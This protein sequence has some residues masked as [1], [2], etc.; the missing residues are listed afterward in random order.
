MCDSPK[1][2]TGIPRVVNINKLNSK[3]LEMT[4]IMKIFRKVDD[5]FGTQCNKI[6]LNL[7]KK[8]NNNKK[9]QSPK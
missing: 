8:N 4:L 5:A 1:S 2:V 7:Y 3:Y 9:N 6:T